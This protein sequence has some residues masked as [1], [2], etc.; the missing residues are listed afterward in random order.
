M[1]GEPVDIGCKTLAFS[2]WVGPMKFWG[3]P[4]PPTMFRSI[5]G[6]HP[7]APGFNSTGIVEEAQFP[8]TSQRE[9]LQSL[10][11]L[12]LSLNSERAISSQNSFVLELHGGLR[13][14]KSACH[15]F[16]LLSLLLFANGC[17]S[18]QAAAEKGGLKVVDHAVFSQPFQ[19]S[20]L[21]SLGFL[22]IFSG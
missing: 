17:V 21:T 8:I 3:S 2:G 15:C 10:T 22:D 9:S 6:M 18:K 7:R 20:T 11:Y 1:R 4:G 12:H 16:A 19:E 5:Q 13:P 14:A